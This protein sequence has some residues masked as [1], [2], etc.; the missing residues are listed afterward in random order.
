[1]SDFMQFRTGIKSIQRGYASCV[2][3]TNSWTVTISTINT[4]KAFFT[5]ESRNCKGRIT[6]STQ[7]TFTQDNP[8]GSSESYWEVVEFH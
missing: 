7:I 3:Q 8:N 1:M 6:G 4:A 2:P 5:Q